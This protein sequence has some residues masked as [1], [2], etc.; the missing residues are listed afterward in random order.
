MEIHGVDG[1]QLGDRRL[2]IT[3]LESEAYKTPTRHP[4]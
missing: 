4:V 1:E 2:A 3:R